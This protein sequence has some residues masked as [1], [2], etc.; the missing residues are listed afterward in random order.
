MATVIVLIVVCAAF[1]YAAL[2]WHHRDHD[3]MVRLAADIGYEL[4][5]D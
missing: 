4:S 2:R 3:R 1:A 5:E